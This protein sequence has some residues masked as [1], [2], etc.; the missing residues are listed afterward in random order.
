[1][2][3]EFSCPGTGKIGEVLMVRSAK[4]TT[5]ALSYRDEKVGVAEIRHEAYPPG[6]YLMEGVNGCGLWENRSPLPYTSLRINGREWMVDDPLHWIGMQM[7]A[8]ESRGRVFVGGLGLGLVVHALAAN[9]KVTEII[10]AEREPSII[11]LIG[12]YLPPKVLVLRGDVYEKARGIL[13]PFDTVILDIWVGHGTQ[14]CHQEMEEARHFFRLHSPKAKFMVWGSTEPE[15]NPAITASPDLLQR[16]TD[17][18]RE[19]AMQ[20]SF[21][22][23]EA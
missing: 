7:L 6:I 5:P 14:V 3:D 17:M 18:K 15:S 22:R 9:P 20:A 16:I 2:T 21:V 19:M 11:E 8:R 13:V 23:V 1:M 10:V 4:W 12:K